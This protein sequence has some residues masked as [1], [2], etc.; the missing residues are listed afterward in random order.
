MH[1][2][3]AIL[4][5]LALLAHPTVPATY[6]P[7]NGPVEY[8]NDY[9]IYAKGRTHRGIDMFANRGAPVLAPED[10]TV[11]FGKGRKGGLVAWLD[12]DGGLRYYFA[13]LDDRNLTVAGTRG[14]A[15]ALLGWVGNTCKARGTS[16]HLHFSMQIHGRFHSPYDQLEGTCP[17]LRYRPLVYK[18]IRIE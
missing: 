9:G 16:P 5:T 7:V 17:N 3:V 12:A 2:L 14:A 13:H 8:S 11:T 18:G 10:G 15:G 4:L 6:C 1:I